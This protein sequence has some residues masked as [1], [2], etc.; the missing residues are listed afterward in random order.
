M[1]NNHKKSDDALTAQIRKEYPAFLDAH[2]IC[3]T[4]FPWRRMSFGGLRE[5]AR[6]TDGEE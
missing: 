1:A 4:R 6:K 2:G 3:I 5:F